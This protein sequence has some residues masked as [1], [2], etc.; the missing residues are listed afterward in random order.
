VNADDSPQLAGP[1]HRDWLRLNNGDLALFRQPSEMFWF[2]QNLKRF[3]GFTISTRAIS[4]HDSN[5]PFFCL[6]DVGIEDEITVIY[7]LGRWLSD[8]A[9]ARI[10]FLSNIHLKSA[11]VA[12]ADVA[13]HPFC[14]FSF[15]YF[16]V[17][18]GLPGGFCLGS[19][20]G[21]AFRRISDRRTDCYTSN[22]PQTTLSTTSA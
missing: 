14:F 20:L 18:S 17:R 11:Q 2:D 7:S 13:W 10:L 16:V 22:S 15:F 9:E 3:S 12:D 6:P 8:F 21:F 4:L 5:S 19:E 1:L